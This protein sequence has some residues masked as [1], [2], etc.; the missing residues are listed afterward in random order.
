MSRP[1]YVYSIG[2]EGKAWD[3]PI[4]DACQP[5]GYRLLDDG[6]LAHLYRDHNEEHL[7]D[8]HLLNY[9]FRQPDQGA[10]KRVTRLLFWDEHSS[11]FPFAAALFGIPYKVRTNPFAPVEYDGDWGDQSNP[12]SLI[13]AHTS[14]VQKY[15]Q[16]WMELTSQNLTTF[17]HSGGLG[18]PTI[19]LVE[20]L[21]E[22]LSL[23]W[24]LRMEGHE[25]I[26][27][28][29]IPLPVSIPRDEDLGLLLKTWISEFFKYHQRPNHVFVISQSVAL[30]QQREFAEWLKPH[31]DESNIRFVDVWPARHRIPVV[32]AFESE[33]LI[34]VRRQGRRAAWLRPQSQ[35]AEMFGSDV[36]WMVDLVDEPSKKRSPFELFLPP[37]NTTVEI[38]NAPSPPTVHHSLVRVYGLG[39]D[40]INIR[41]NNKE[42]LVSHWLPTEEEILEERVH[43]H[44]PRI[45]KDEKRSCYLPAIKLLGGLEQASS[46]LSGK[47]GAI[48]QELANGPASEHELKGRLQLGKGKIPELTRD[49]DFE[50]LLQQLTPVQ[51]RI[52]RRRLQHYWRRTLPA[53]S[54][55]QSLL[56]HWVS[57]S[58]LRRVW[59]IGPCPTCQTTHRESRLNVGR[60]YKCSGCSSTI[61]LP[62]SFVVEYEL[63]PILYTA[64]KEG[65]RP[66][67]LTGNFLKN[68]T[69]KGFLWLPGLKYTD[70]NVDGDLDIV[71]SCDGHLVLA[72]CKLRDESDPQ[73]IEW[74]KILD[75]IRAMAKIGRTCKA[76]LIV[77]ASLLP[78]YP[79][80][81]LAEVA[82][83]AGDDLR[84][85]VLNREDLENGHRWIHD[86]KLSMPYP[87]PLRD[88]IPDRIHEEPVPK[89]D[90]PRVIETGGF[91]ITVGSVPPP[92]SGPSD[93]D[94]SAPA[95]DTNENP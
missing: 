20:N 66:V 90:E 36:S 75:Q 72:E 84:I 85:E 40:S 12:A 39:V 77:F 55:L 5:R 60:P 48:L 10:P 1:D 95:A 19:V 4:R 30:D 24:N 67:A 41:C 64:L 16:S 37:G 94:G 25:W 58:I 26:P 70:Q 18:H 38:L 42:E 22:D 14:I 6:F 27:R 47:R 23:F 80:S 71:A 8:R 62:E 29:I 54:K 81:F 69:H 34:E 15:E 44:G 63:Q 46:T 65:L 17:Y 57:N 9:L 51:K 68:L 2:L 88:L 56:E 83:I 52:G 50:F 45:R 49:K 59:R 78:D 28:W 86:E 89:F 13:K 53:N 87:L 74:S 91:T 31:L 43:A 11:V 73:E 79:Q 61:A 32:T 82:T 21:I 93:R 92:P 35:V 3:S 7:T 76:E 33:K